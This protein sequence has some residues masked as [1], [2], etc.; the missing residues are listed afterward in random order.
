MVEDDTAD[1]CRDDPGREVTVVVDATVRGLTE[2]CPVT[3]RQSK[4]CSLANSA[5]TAHGA[6]QAGSGFSLCASAF[7][8]TRSKAVRSAPT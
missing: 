8:P 1:L 7:A 4:S 3:V 5:S 6:K 2:V